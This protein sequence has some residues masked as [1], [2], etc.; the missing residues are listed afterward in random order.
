MGLDVIATEPVRLLLS[1]INGFIQDDAI[2][3][4]NE[5]NHKRLAEIKDIFAQMGLDVGEAF[6]QFGI[7]SRDTFD[8]A[9]SL[10][11]VG[12]LESETLAKSIL[13]TATSVFGDLEKAFLASS[14]NIL[15]NFQQFVGETQEDF[16][17]RRSQVL[18]A[19]DDDRRNISKGFQARLDR[20]IANLENAGFQERLDIDQRFRGAESQAIQNLTDRGLGG[21]TLASNVGLGVTRERSAEQRRLSEQ[22]R[23]ERSDV[24]AR[25][26]GDALN[27]QQ[28]LSLARADLDRALSGDTLSFQTVAGLAETNLQTQ[29]AKS[30]FDVGVQGAALEAGLK[31]NLLNVIAS[32]NQKEID[33][34]LARGASEL[35]IAKEEFSV[36]FGLDLERI[37]VIERVSD[38]VSP[39]GVGLGLGQFLGS[40]GASAQSG[41]GSPG[42]NTAGQ[43][44]GLAGAS[45]AVGTATIAAS[46]GL[47]VAGTAGGIVAGKA[48]AAIFTFGLGALACLDGDTPIET[49]EGFKPIRDIKVGDRVRSFDGEFYAVEAI[50]SGDVPE[51]DREQY[52]EITDGDGRAIVVTRRHPIAGRFAGVWETG[53]VM[54]GVGPITVE[55]HD[56][57][58]GHDIMIEGNR[59]YMANGFRVSSVLGICIAQNPEKLSQ[60][61]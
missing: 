48:V 16:E 10:L 5:A 52:F 3:S 35:G 19:F 34:A 17:D 49:S 33:L 61:Q 44:A 18:A 12:N 32:G 27:S 38:T 28:Q 1:L 53:D 47:A 20:G 9:E 55:R 29:Q 50:D 4:A 24:D 22:I 60:F 41:G 30:E 8:K 45:A 58:I 31:Q 57:V 21:T 13:K 54:D 23:R 36:Q 2:K 40:S 15:D 46:G 51:K 39:G 11:T 59:D 14:E 26:S 7:I 37:R 43:I 56:Y 6:D 42:S 25:L